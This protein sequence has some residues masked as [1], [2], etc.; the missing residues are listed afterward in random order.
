MALLGPV[1]EAAADTPTVRVTRPAV[2]R[3]VLDLADDTVAIRKEISADRSEVTMTTSRDRLSVSI[4]RGVVTVS[5]PAGSITVNPSEEVDSERLLV[6]LQRS[7][8]ARRARALLDRV[9]EGPNSFVGQSVL[10]TRAILEIGTGSVNA[11]NE[12]RKWVAERAAQIAAPA[13]TPGTP[14]VIRASLDVL[15]KYG[16]GDCWDLY[17][18][19]AIRIADDFGDCTDDLRWYEA[20][21]WAGCSLIYAVRSEAAMAWFISCNGGVPFNG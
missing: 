20:H 15:Q 4:R 21:K 12:H 11:M 3:I 8:A 7:E 13:K 2:G 17:S 19:E 18:Q 16:P 9:E 14:M 10:L 6:V 1:T 5:G